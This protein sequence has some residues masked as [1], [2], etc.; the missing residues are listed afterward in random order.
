MSRTDAWRMVQRRVEA[1]GIR[2][3]FG[4]HSIRASAITN[5]LEGGGSLE[6]AQRL[7]GHADKRTTALY[8]RREYRITRA[9]I[10]SINFRRER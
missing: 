9:D 2:G 10:E 5:Y 8:D 3:E 1:A 6:K 7:A 4:C